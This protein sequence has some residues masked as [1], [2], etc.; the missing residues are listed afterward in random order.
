MLASLAAVLAAG[1][2]LCACSIGTD[3]S[4]QQIPRKS[5]PFGLL[6][7][8]SSTTVPEAATDGITV[9]LEV[10]SHLITVNR[11][12]P[13]PATIRSALRALGRGPTSAE[14]AAGITSPVS[15]AGPLSMISHSGNTVVV[16]VGGSFSALSGQ[17]QIV[18]AAQVVYTLT[19]FPGVHQVVIRV[20]GQRTL[21]PTATGRISSSPLTRSAYASLAPL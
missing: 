3:A 13:A 9:F 21:V 5:V 7:P 1:L 17:D 19:L 14:S 2:L 10:E 11:L 8:N 12:V 6:A 18:A 16:N 4:P 15:T 20:G